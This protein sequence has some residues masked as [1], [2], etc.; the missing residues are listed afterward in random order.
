MQAS[1]SCCK[2]GKEKRGFEN[3]KETKEVRVYKC[4]KTNELN[5]W[6]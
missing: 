5:N 6:K 2:L 3:E 1:T 4:E